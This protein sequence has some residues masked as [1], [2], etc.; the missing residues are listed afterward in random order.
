MGGTDPGSGSAA[1]PVSTQTRCPTANPATG[2]ATAATYQAGLTRQRVATT[3][4]AVRPALPSLVRATITAATVGPNRASSPNSND[5]LSSS[6][7]A[8]EIATAS[9]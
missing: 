8:T 3:R 6:P 2:R 4:R 9:T 1:C 7:S 5:T